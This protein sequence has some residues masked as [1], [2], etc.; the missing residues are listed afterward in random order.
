MREQIGRVLRELV[1]VSCLEFKP[2]MDGDSNW[3]MFY[4]GFGY[5]LIDHLI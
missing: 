2:K 1:F 3:I 4:D 5:V